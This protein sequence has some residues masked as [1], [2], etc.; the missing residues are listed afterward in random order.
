LQSVSVIIPAYNE[1]DT[2]GETIKVIKNIDVVNEIIV[3]NDGSTDDTGQI[4]Q[5]YGVKVVNLY[6]N[7]GKGGAMNAAVSHIHNDIVV[8][9]DA[10]LGTTAEQA[11]KIIQPVIDKKTDICIAAF[12]PPRKKGGF[13]IVKRTAAWI[14]YKVGKVRVQSPLSGQRAM[15][16]EALMALI[17]F[18]EG[19]GVELAMTVK[20]LRLGFKIKEVTTTMRHKE[21]GRDFKGFLHRGRQ[22]IDVLKVI[23]S[24]VRGEHI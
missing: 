13:G 3:I 7:R 14:I 1:E 10:D 15:T 18:G 5:R 21:T 24:E 8:F 2:I 23:K 9:L 16:R 12:P 22:F 11:I 6:P 17:P 4:A 19:Y 20:A